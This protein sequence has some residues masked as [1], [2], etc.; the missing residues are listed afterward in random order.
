MSRIPKNLEEILP[1]VVED[2]KRIYADDLVSVILYG[3]AAG[4]NYRPGRSDINLMVVLTEHGIDAL[5]RAF[6]ITAKWKKA[7]VATPLFVTENYIRTSL[8]VFPVEYLNFQKNHRVVYGKDILAG[9]T[10]SSDFMRLQCEREIKAKLVVLRQAFV[11]TGGKPAGLTDLMSDS[12]RA[13]IAIFNGLLYMKDG[14]L[15]D[16]KQDILAEACKVFGLDKA[17][18]IRVLALQEKTGKLSKEELRALFS[19]YL[20][21]IRNLWHVVD[22]LAD[23]A[24]GH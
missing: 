23:P 3:S 4:G 20:K 1:A 14:R 13:F 17:V 11:E 18:F 22:S 15:P 2:Y 9:L 19:D 12:L 16:R 7:R 5:E 10:F 21:Q 8:D 24:E 6:E